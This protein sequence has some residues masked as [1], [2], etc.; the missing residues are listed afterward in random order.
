MPLKRFLMHYRQKHTALHEAVIRGDDEGV[1]ALEL[2]LEYVFN[3]KTRLKALEELKVGKEE[4]LITLRRLDIAVTTPTLKWRT[5]A[6]R[7]R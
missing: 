7:R 5:F 1:K 6:V 2:L 3:T 4:S